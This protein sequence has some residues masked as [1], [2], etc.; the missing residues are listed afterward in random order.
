[1]WI[2]IRQPTACSGIDSV[3]A[4]SASGPAWQARQVARGHAA[5]FGGFGLRRPP[6]NWRHITD[7]GSRRRRWNL[8]ALFFLLVV[9]CLF[10]M[11]GGT[12]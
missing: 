11:V 6:M 12:G 1:M 10:F 9:V 4:A 5:A 2:R 8:V 7:G 3:H